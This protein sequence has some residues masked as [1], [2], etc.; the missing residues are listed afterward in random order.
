MSRA[1]VMCASC[2]CVLFKI[3]AVLGMEPRALKVSL[4]SSGV[5]KLSTPPSIQRRG[6][7]IV[8]P[9][10]HVAAEAVAA[11]LCKALGIKTQLVPSLL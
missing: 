4:P 10:C 5:I 6:K 7:N 3:L 1:H 11:W 8:P 2:V 9:A